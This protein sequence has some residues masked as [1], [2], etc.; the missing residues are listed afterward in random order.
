MKNKVSAWVWIGLSIVTVWSIAASAGCPAYNS[1]LIESSPRR[2]TNL[3]NL[4]VKHD[5]DGSADINLVYPDVGMYYG[6]YGFQMSHNGE[7]RQI[8]N[9]FKGGIPLTVSGDWGITVTSPN[10]G[11]S[12]TSTI[13]HV[14]RFN[15]GR[16]EVTTSDIARGSFS[17]SNAGAFSNSSSSSSASRTNL[18]E[19]T[20]SEILGGVG[21]TGM[22]GGW[23]EASATFY[24]NGL[25]MVRG[26]AR[27]DSNTSGVYA[28]Y[29]VVG[30]DRRGRAIFVSNVLKMPTV[31]SKLD[32]C[33]HNVSDTLRDNINPEIAKYVVKI[34]VYAKTTSQGHSFREAT[35]RTITE[36]CATYDDLP[37][38]ARAAIALE[39]GFPGCN[40]LK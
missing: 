40:P 25:L 29:I 14:A 23:A 32:T 11:T 2:N 22:G 10:G 8:T 13:A 36:A 18:A 5:F 26:H 38:I 28:A 7:V 1:T 19:E 24:R 39:T 6:G 35:I 37:A 3:G 9:D 16:Y 31:C 12:C 33:S 34:D 4:V 30:V 21:P 27:S 17:D 20:S 15:N